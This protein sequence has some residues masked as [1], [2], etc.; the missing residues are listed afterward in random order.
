MMP[1]LD[2]DFDCIV[3]LN[4][5][6]RA[7]L[8][9]IRASDTSL[10]REGFTRLSAES[11]AMRFFSAIRSLSDQAARY[12]TD[13]DGDS[14]AALIAVTIPD[15]AA[16]EHGLG[17]ARFVRSKGDRSVAELAVTIVD[18]SQR[19]GLGVLLT[20]T[21]GAAARARGI[22]TFTMD[23]LWNN[24]KVMHLLRRIGAECRRRSGEVLTFSVD[25]ASLASLAVERWHEAA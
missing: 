23:V 11:R 17:V 2:P 13:V 15:S 8:R 18:D 6:G 7:R 19:L 25:T 12:L 22:E 3:T 21:L 16:E 1:Y 24:S 10:L 5:G 9:W 20:V 14:H 4:D